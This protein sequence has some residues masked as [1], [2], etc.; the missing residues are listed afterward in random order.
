MEPDELL[1]AHRAALED[2]AEAQLRPYIDRVRSGNV[3]AESKEFNDP[4]WGTI[5]LDP[6]EV[7][8]LDSP[9]LQRLRRIR[10][11]GVVHLV[12][13]GAG[14]TRLEHSI[15]VVHQVQQIADSLNERDLVG[16]TDRLP[17]LKPLVETLRLA[18]LCHDTGHGA[19]SHVSEYALAGNK[20]CRNL[21]PAFGDHAEV[22]HE[23]QLSEIA[24][25][26]L[27]GS[28]AFTELLALAREKLCLPPR[29]DQASQV[30]SLIVGKPID[31]ELV[32]AREMISGPYDA[33][34][35]DYLA[36]DAVMCGVPIV[37]DV[38][39]LIQKV[40][41]TR[42][43]AEQLPQKLQQSLDDRPGGFIITGLA[44]SGGS[45]LMELSLARVLMFDKVYRHHAVRAAEAIVFEIVGR[46]AD[47]SPHR[48]GIVPL[49]LTDDQLLD[50][51]VAAI[52]RFIGKE[53]DGLDEAEASQVATIA[54]LARRLRERRLFARAFAIAGTMTN[55]AFKED[56]AHAMGLKLFLQ[57]F[58]RAQT[59]RKIR[60]A[61]CERLRELILLLDKADLLAEFEPH[62]EAYVHLSPPKPAPKTIGTDNDHAFLIDEDGTLTSVTDDAPETS[63]WSD[64]Y[65]ATHDLGH[66]FCPAEIAPYVFLAAEIELRVERKVH[67]PVSMLPYA[68]QHKRVLDAIRRDLRAKGFYDNL[69]QDLRPDPPSFA[70][71]GFSARVEQAGRKLH[72]YA[73]PVL[74]Q[75]EPVPELLAAVRVRNFVKQ[76]DDD[77]TD[78]ALRT[79]SE[80]KQISRD[81][82][83]DATAAF[84]DDHPD[85]VGAS[86]CALGSPKDSSSI[87]INF[88][89]DVAAKYGVKARTLSDALAADEPILFVDDFIGRGSQTKDIIQNWLA[90]ETT[91]TLNEER[92]T[93][94]AADQDRLR[95]RKVGFAYVAGLD[96][97]R[98]TLEE[99]LAEH[100]IDA[101]VHVHIREADI[102]TLTSVFGDEEKFERFEG[103]MREAGARALT[104]HHGKTRSDQWRQDR[105]L[106]YGGHALLFTSMFNTP[107]AAL[108]AL[109]AGGSMSSWQ[110]IFPRRSKN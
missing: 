67:I 109:W 64:A 76:F 14:H 86:L 106:G 89:L 35:L 91:E 60:D 27:V 104:N 13:M 75:H 20:E 47:L 50:L 83:A 52:C 63:G 38:T 80:T 37:T 22:A 58:G 54:D 15:G 21:I 6:L 88:A 69:P 108:T 62:L 81:D 85:F 66:I 5:R 36:R 110:P 68:K 12:Y 49:L 93:L 9:L 72:S 25:Y 92:D 87:Y 59:R 26:L 79:V 4:I 107:T 40:R 28:P 96:E 56:S 71:A 73:G 94:T 34:K 102:P 77:L 39:R 11:L 23:N 99:F 46:L 78:L 57:D 82:V 51:N 30:Q 61:I 19:M 70:R 55:D 1:A 3:A 29:E 45:T 95:A 18:A 105:A 2:F 44:R 10:Q 74:K 48:P 16:S 101:K 17:D 32:L 90:L 42:A 43:R 97:G 98:P 53:L 8:I 7:V 41:A 31:N 103:F 33:D 100:S 24:S 84:I 65:I